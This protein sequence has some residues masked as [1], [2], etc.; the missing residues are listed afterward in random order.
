[1][2]ALLLFYT[3]RDPG[4]GWPFPAV[5]SYR[6]AGIFAHTEASLTHLPTTPAAGLAEEWPTLENPPPD[7]LAE[8]RYAR[9]TCS[10]AISW[11]RVLYQRVAGA[12]TVHLVRDGGQ[13]IRCV[14][15]KW[16][17]RLDGRCRFGLVKF[18]VVASGE[19]LLLSILHAIG[20]YYGN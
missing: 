4:P 2:P 19:W 18:F 15:K 13:W 16:S 20:S 12:F 9:I 8:S 5:T 6:D 3:R 17:W 7:W 1:M 10:S 14:R 11:L